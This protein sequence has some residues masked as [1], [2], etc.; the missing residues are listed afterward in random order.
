MNINWFDLFGKYFLM[1]SDS[2][3]KVD[4]VYPVISLS[5]AYLMLKK[6]WLNKINCK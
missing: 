1:K 5:P 3:N 4:Y 6:Q 2:N